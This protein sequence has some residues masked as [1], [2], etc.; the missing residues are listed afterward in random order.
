MRKRRKINKPLLVTIIVLFVLTAAFL[1]YC[2]PYY[3]AEGFPDVKSTNTVNI[4]SEKHY[5]FYDGPG[6]KEALIF[7]PGAKVESKAYE[8]LL[9][10]LSEEGTDCFLVNMP[11]HIAI[12]GKNRANEIISSYDYDDYI[13]AGHS[14]GGAMASSYAKAHE[15]K[16]NK[17][18]FLASYGTQ[19]FS[20]DENLKILSI[21]GSNDKVIRKEAYN[22]AVS[23]YPENGFTEYVIKGGNHSGFSYYGPQK[24]DGEADISKEEQI[25][26][27]LQIITDWL[28]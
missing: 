27:T 5:T 10:K 11:L 15:D 16:V 12:F 26:E 3:H 28:K 19:D 18:I 22:K 8:A 24:G 6:E 20:N 2:L 14:L 9:Y 4:I 13:M 21:Y 1:G 25:N 7:Y 17:I 23:L